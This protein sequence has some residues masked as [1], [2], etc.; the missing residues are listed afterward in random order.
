[1]PA[2]GFEAGA[3]QHHLFHPT[4]AERL[5][6]SAEGFVIGFASVLVLVS[7]TLMQA[8]LQLLQL[9]L[10]VG[11]AQ[12]VERHRVALVGSNQDAGLF[13]R[14]HERREQESRFNVHRRQL[15]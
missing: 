14:Q 1:M 10:P 4:L 15:H 6:A 3:C 12:L 5:V 11:I 13:A 2:Q 8:G 7:S 9:L